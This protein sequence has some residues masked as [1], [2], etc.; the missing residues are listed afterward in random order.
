MELRMFNMDLEPLG[1]IDEAVSVIWQPSYWDKGDYGDVKILAPI[2]DNNTALLVKGNIIVR[3]G[4]SAEYTDEKGEWRRAAQIT[5]RFISKDINGAEQIEVQGCFLKKWLSKRLITDQL[6]LT[7]TNQNIINT[8]V[9]QNFGEDAPQERQ[10]ERFTMLAQDDLG[11]SS[12]EYSA[13]FGASAEDEIYNRALVGKLG[14][15][16]LV[17]ERARLYGF[18]L[19]KGKDLTATNTQ[20]NTPCIFSRD[21]DNVN[22]QEYT[23]SIE[24]MK[25]TAYVAGAADSDGTQP[26]I[27]VWKD[28]EEAKGWDRDELFIEA[29]DI[30]RTTKDQSGQ[31]VAIPLEQYLQLMATKADGEL[32]NYGE[33]VSFVSTISTSKNLQYK[34]DFTVG[35]IVTS[36][37]KRWG[38][39]IDARITKI[40]QTSQNGQETL[41]VTFGE[42]LPTLIEKIKQKVR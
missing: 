42:S 23:E 7:D 27:E 22:E 26:R 40:N 33:C 13:E 31:D 25:N 29:T 17:N 8:I 10:G 41:E 1:I 2:T 30:S 34:K 24:S 18:W 36:I 32:E 35:D 37:E 11:G 3:H 5:Y 38:I 20:G 16:I 14:F 39:K 15:D 9:R 21:F 28:G 6:M 4:E 12:V 19:Y